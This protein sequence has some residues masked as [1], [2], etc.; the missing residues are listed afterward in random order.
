MKNKPGLYLS[1]S[2]EF[3]KDAES[4]R[5]YMYRKLHYWYNVIIPVEAQPPF[6]K[7]DPEYA[8]FIKKN[9]V[10]PDMIDVTTSKYF[11]VKLDK[12]VFKGAGTQGEITSA[13]FMGKHIIAYLDGIKLEKIPGWIIGCLDDATFVDSIDEAIELYRIEAKELKQKQK[14]REEQE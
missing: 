3:S 5:K 12:A 6:E 10:I 11:F 1:G 9:F 2:I 8:A 4:W 7:T 13:C 14:E